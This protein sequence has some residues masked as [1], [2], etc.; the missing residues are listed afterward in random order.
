MVW[1]SLG[2]LCH[3]DAFKT[4][5]KLLLKIFIYTQ[6][7]IKN[8]DANIINS[9]NLCKVHKCVGAGIWQSIQQLAVGWKVQV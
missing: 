3:F 5:G 7:K 4:E 2:H 1:K 9:N 8:S 6:H